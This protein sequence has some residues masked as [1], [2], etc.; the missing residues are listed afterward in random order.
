MRPLARLEACRIDQLQRHRGPE[1]EVVGAP[2][3]PHPAAADPRDHPIAARKHLAGC[4]GGRGLIRRVPSLFRLFVV[5][6]EQR[7]DLL[8]QGGVAAA[9]LRQEGRT[10]GGRPLERGQKQLLRA[11]V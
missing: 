7:L 4:E 6:R 5:K 1:N 2:D 10:V 8:P 3:I 9:R 11:L